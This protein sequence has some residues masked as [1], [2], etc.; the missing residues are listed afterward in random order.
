[1]FGN[2]FAYMVQVNTELVN[3]LQEIMKILHEKMLQ[4]IGLYWFHYVSEK[5]FSI[6]RP[7]F[8]IL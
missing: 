1:M 2:N 7:Y 5:N 3:I 8:S 6:N 4:A